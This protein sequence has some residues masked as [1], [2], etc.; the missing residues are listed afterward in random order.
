MFVLV[1]VATL[2]LF[3]GSTSATDQ[4]QHDKTTLFESLQLDFVQEELK[5]PIKVAHHRLMTHESAL[6]RSENSNP[7]FG[8]K[9]ALLQGYLITA[10]YID[11]ACTAVGSSRA[12]QLN[13][14]IL[15][16]SLP[17]FYEITTSREASTFVSQFSLTV[18]YEDSLCSVKKSEGPALLVSPSCS[19][20]STRSFVS[21][22]P[23]PI[24]SAP[25]LLL[26]QVFAYWQTKLKRCD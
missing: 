7:L 21:D 26:R 10:I 2:F 25:N 14:C 1:L 8:M 15:S 18:F 22:L 13:K 5:N 9:E 20:T 24:S 12:V 19:A 23:T 3:S 4:L 11:K 17:G 16:N 6:N